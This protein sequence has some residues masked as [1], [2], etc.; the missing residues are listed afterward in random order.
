MV[1]NIRPMIEIEFP[2]DQRSVHLI[3]KRQN[4]RQEVIIDFYPLT[5]FGPLPPVKKVVYLFKG[6]IL[7]GKI[8][9]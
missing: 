8:V 9:N 4:F 2:T 6:D 7:K 3:H 1:S 5:H